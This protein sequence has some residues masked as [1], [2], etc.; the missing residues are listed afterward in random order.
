M[1]P[2]PHVI[3]HMCTTIDG[4]I[5]AARW[6]KL[7]SSA[8]KLFEKTADSFKVGA[9]IV[10]TTTMREFSG[11]PGKLPRARRPAS[12]VDHLANPGAKTFAIGA[13]AKGVLRFREPEV[14]GDHVVVLVTEQV[15]SDYLAH[16]AAAGVSYLFCGDA[17]VDPKVAL[18]KLRGKLGVTKL[19]LEG[20]GAFNGA[21]LAAGLVD[22]VSQVILPI[23]DGGA[24]VASIFDIAGPTR[25]AAATLRLQSHEVLAGGAIWARY[26]VT[27]Q[28]KV[29]KR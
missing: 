17:R 8:S 11:R 14:D 12:R 9:W 18:A 29:S 3:C 16:L 26:R 22:E 23:V 27:G 25:R 28:V 6:G 2:R 24:G 10:G 1:K 5:L 20:G 13:D 7:A 4:K 19:M 21:V 15:S